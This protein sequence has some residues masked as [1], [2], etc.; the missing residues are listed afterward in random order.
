MMPMYWKDI[1]NFPGYQASTNGEIRSIDRINHVGRR[2]KGRVLKSAWWGRYKGVLLCIKGKVYHRR[3]SVLV[4]LAFR[5]PANGR[6]AL[7][8]NDVRSDNRLRNL[9]WGTQKQ[10]GKDAIR[11]GRLKGERKMTLICWVVL[12]TAIVIV[13]LS[14]LGMCIARMA[15]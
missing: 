4:L 13:C 15:K 2:M 3:V 5:G 11:N 9:R 7:H 1:P 10:N 14:F 12:G 8:K 6:Y